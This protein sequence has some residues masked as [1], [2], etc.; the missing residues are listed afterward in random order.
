[1]SNLLCGN[2]GSGSIVSFKTGTVT[3]CTANTT[4]ARTFTIDGLAVGDYVQVQKPTHQAGLG[5]V[6]SRVSAANTL[7]ITYGNYTGSTIVPTDETCQ[8][9]WI[10]SDST[11][12]A[13]N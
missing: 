10:R 12:T 6:N 4:V 8:L 11:K 9:I 5:I 7:E 3:T 13:A 1:M 2:I